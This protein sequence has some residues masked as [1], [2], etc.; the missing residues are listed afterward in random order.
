MIGLADIRVE[1]MAADQWNMRGVIKVVHLPT[2][3]A[4]SVPYSPG[5]GQHRART[6]ALHM[7]DMIL[8]EVQP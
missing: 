1:L 2:G 6:A 4:V 3:A 8:D 5:Y 7:L